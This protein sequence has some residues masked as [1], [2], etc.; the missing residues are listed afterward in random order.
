MRMVWVSSALI[1]IEGYREVRLMR[2]AGLHEA[3]T[4]KVAGPTSRAPR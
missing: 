2:I 3:V 4:V 1:A